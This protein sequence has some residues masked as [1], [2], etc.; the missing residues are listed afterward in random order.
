MTHDHQVERNIGNYIITIE[1]CIFFSKERTCRAAQITCQV[2]VLGL[3][4]RE[5]LLLYFNMLCLFLFQHP[6]K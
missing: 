6:N 2:L 3:S 1:E 4:V 5:D